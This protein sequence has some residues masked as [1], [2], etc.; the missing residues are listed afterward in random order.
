MIKVPL[1]A[2][3]FIFTY[4]PS[5]AMTNC[6]ITDLGTTHSTASVALE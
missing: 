4:S 6:V 2:F 3:A 1:F 5:F